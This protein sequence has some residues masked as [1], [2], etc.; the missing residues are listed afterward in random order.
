MRNEVQYE[1]D[2]EGTWYV[3]HDPPFAP[4]PGCLALSFGIGNMWQLDQM[5]KFGREVHAFDPSILSK[6]TSEMDQPSGDSKITPS[7]G[8]LLTLL[9]NFYENC[10]NTAGKPSDILKDYLVTS[11]SISPEVTPTPSSE[12][13]LDPKKHQQDPLIYIIAVLAFYSVGILIM[14]V[15]YLKRERREL[16]EEK[17]LDEFIKAMRKTSAPSRGQTNRP[18]MSS[19]PSFPMLTRVSSAIFD[20]PN[21]RN[22]VGN[23]LDV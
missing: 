8:T 10:T 20:L 13:D 6:M 11:S 21:R 7:F 5:A 12:S 22:T 16:E 1:A 17:V 2:G 19:K 15:K 3:C 23:V 14:M 9:R 4:K 18:R